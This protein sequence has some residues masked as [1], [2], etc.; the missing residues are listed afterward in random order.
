MA[1]RVSSNCRLQNV[2]IRILFLNAHNLDVP[3]EIEAVPERRRISRIY[4]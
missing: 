3:A 4:P 2:P 1:V